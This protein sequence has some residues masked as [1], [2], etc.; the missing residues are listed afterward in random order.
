[1]ALQQLRIVCGS[2]PP[3]NAA[4]GCGG[5]ESERRENKAASL[6]AGVGAPALA[7]SLGMT[8][9]WGGKGVSEALGVS[10]GV[11]EGDGVLLLVS[12]PLGVAGRC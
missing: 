10:L 1:M 8:A 9:D 2:A 7:L 4:M 12:E 5:R 6:E 3:A 11:V